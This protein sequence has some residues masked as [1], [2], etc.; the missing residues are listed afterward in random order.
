MRT[1]SSIRIAASNIADHSQTEWLSSVSQCSHGEGWDSGILPAIR[2]PTNVGTITTSG[3]TAPA[4]HAACTKCA[5]GHSSA[6]PHVAIAKC[7]MVC[8][9]SSVRCKRKHSCRRAS[10]AN[11]ADIRISEAQPSF[12]Q[13]NVTEPQRLVLS[14]AKGRSLR[15]SYAVRHI[16]SSGRRGNGPDR[17]RNFVCAALLQ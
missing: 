17:T 13:Q 8:R 15:T 14:R 16:C 6:A 9:I 11:L 3:K 12:P 10:D 5:S 4:T 1:I 2:S 7:V